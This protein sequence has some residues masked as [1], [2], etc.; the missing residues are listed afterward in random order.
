ML[1]L[2]AAFG[3]CVLAQFYMARQVRRVLAHKHPE[4]WRDLSSRA[5]FIDNAV[6][7]FVWKKRYK[8]LADPELDQLGRWMCRLQLLGFVIWLAYAA[9]IF[10]TFGSAD[11]G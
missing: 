5:F 10:T 9:S 8:A 2:F 6:V 3:G 4:T 11:R 1:V 7:R